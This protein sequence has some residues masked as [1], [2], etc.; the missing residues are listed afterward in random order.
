MQ[1]ESIAVPN[2]LTFRHRPV[3]KPRAL[4]IFFHGYADHSGSFMRRLYPEGLP[5]SLSDIAILAPNGP[6]PTPV[7][8]ENGWREAYAWYFYIE[9]ED[10][11]MIDPSAAAKASELLIQKLGYEELPKILIGFSQGGFFAPY[12]ASRIQNVKEVVAI[13]A[14]Y[15]SDFYPTNQNWKITAIHG[16]NDSMFPIDNTRRAHQKILQQ[17]YSGEFIEIPSLAHE[18]SAE[19]GSITTERILALNLKNKN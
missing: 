3:E 13:G 12:L 2:T 14:G 19:L 1:L 5:E 11:M 16:S 9:S 8:S 7:K 18:V 4:A 6:F 10:R 15:R 17:G